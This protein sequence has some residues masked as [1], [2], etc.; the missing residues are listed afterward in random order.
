MLRLAHQIWKNHLK[1]GDVAVDATAGN[2]YDTLFLFEMEPS[3]LYVFDIQKKAIENTQIRVG[4]HK[5]I[6][7]H[8]GCHST[9]PGVERPVNLIVYNLGY[10]P[11]GDKSLT[12][13]GESTV[14]SLETA[15]YL[16]APKGMISVM[17]YSGHLEGEREKETIL[18]WGSHLSSKKFYVSHHNPLNHFKAP[19]LLLI[20]KT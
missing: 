5:N 19:S 18:K 9:F 10:L 4:M 1:A 2:G 3:H 7:Y 8:L 14:K 15:L 20:Y 6:S 17:L 13:K 12:T 16:L 11:G